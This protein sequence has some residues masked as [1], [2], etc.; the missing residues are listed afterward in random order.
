MNFRNTFYQLNFVHLYNKYPNVMFFKCYHD[1]NFKVMEH[2]TILQTYTFFLQT[3]W[4]GPAEVGS[5]TGTFVENKKLFVLRFPQFDDFMLK[6]NDHVTLSGLQ[7]SS[8][9]FSY[10]HTT[11]SRLKNRSQNEG[12]IQIKCKTRKKIR[13]K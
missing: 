11:S 6:I 3:R 13:F 12:N 7:T 4:R 8:S 2:P 9:Y 5:E 1:L 10:N